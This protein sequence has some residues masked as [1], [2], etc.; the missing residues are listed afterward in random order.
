MN[1]LV[2][3][4]CVSKKL[5]YKAR[6][7]K[8]YKSPWFESSMKYAKSLKPHAIFILSAKYGLLALDQEIEPY[9]LTLKTMRKSQ[10]KNW[11]NIVIDQLRC[12][13]DLRNDEFII[14]AGDKYRKYLVPHLDH[15]KIPLKG[16]RIG[17]QL[18]WLKEH[19]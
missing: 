19:S 3:I 5:S 4:S 13:C 1:E 17:E 15:V 16:M 6:A 14:L 18:K 9:D 12:H 11:A 7:E 10:V 2:L 8:L